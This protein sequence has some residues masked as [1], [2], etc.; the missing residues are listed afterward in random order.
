MEILFIVLTTIVVEWMNLSFPL[1]HLWSMLE[2]ANVADAA[3]FSV[4]WMKLDDDDVRSVESRCDL[5]CTFSHFRMLST[6]SH[7]I[8]AWI[9]FK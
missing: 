3:E 9:L 8:R 6:F 1:L 4:N 7:F 5:T 2:T